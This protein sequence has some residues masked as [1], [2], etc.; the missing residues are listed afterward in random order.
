MPVILIGQA[1]VYARLDCLVSLVFV[2]VAA[3]NGPGFDF[4]VFP[5]DF[6]IRNFSN[7]EFEFCTERF[8]GK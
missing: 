2:S 8:L 5:L 6:S 7:T 4:Q 1:E 3:E